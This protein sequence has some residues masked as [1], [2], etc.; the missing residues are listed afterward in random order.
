MWLFDVFNFW[1]T[2]NMPYIYNIGWWRRTL[3]ILKDKSCSQSLMPKWVKWIWFFIWLSNFKWNVYFR[4][5]SIFVPLNTLSYRC[6][7]PHLPHF[8]TACRSQA[9]VTSGDYIGIFINTGFLKGDIPLLVF[10]KLEPLAG[11]TLGFSQQIRTI[12]CSHSR[13]LVMVS[14]EPLFKQGGPFS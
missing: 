1:E 4:S 13:H 2:K 12:N 10:G 14:M 8:S 9:S 6:F 3:I 11:L 7:P 5:S